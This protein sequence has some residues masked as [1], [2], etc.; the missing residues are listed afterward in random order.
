MPFLCRRDFFLHALHEGSWVFRN[1]IILSSTFEERLDCSEIMIGGFR[2]HLRRD[3]IPKGNYVLFRDFGDRLIG[4]RSQEIQKFAEAVSVE[5]LGGG[6][7]FRLLCFQP[8]RHAR[9]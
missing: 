4:A 5:V 7:G 2:R 1:H 9:P 8:A 3:P 6:C